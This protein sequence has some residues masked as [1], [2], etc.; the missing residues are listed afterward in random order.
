MGTSRIQLKG[1]SFFGGAHERA[2]G[3]RRR[4]RWR[5]R[6]RRWQ[7]AAARDAVE[8]IFFFLLIEKY[9]SVVYNHNRFSF[10]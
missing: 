10:Y 5:W 8:M 2:L 4:W 7:V 1:N 9:V 6:W 3:R